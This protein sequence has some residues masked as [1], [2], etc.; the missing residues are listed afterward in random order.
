MLTA[1]QV[2]LRMQVDNSA[3]AHLTVSLLSSEDSLTSLISA[4]ADTGLN[5][6]TSDSLH[7]VVI[8]AILCTLQTLEAQ[9]ACIS[10]RASMQQVCIDICRVIKF[11]LLHG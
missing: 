1:C 2:E 4:A 7:A 9:T 3:A 6:Q 5:P 11:R 8:S 10:A